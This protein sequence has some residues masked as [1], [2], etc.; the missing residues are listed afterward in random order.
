MILIQTDWERRQDLSQILDMVGILLT[1]FPTCGAEY[2]LFFKS[3]ENPLKSFK[4]PS[5]RLNSTKYV[6]HREWKGCGNY[7]SSS[8]VGEGEEGCWCACDTVLSSNS[9]T[10]KQVIYYKNTFVQKWRRRIQIQMYNY[11]RKRSKNARF[12]LYLLM[13]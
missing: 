10:L 1:Q 4:S 3:T 12:L 7:F 11:R 9:F 5:T 6:A 8:E 2:A 13:F